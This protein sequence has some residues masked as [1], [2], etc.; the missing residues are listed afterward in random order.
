M[1]YLKAPLIIILR[2]ETLLVLPV[3]VAFLLVEAETLLAF[4]V[5]GV[6]L[7]S[8]PRQLTVLTAACVMLELGFMN[9]E[10]ACIYDL[11]KHGKIS[12]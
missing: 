11:F 6:R 8:P 12:Q 3:K 9:F 4:T 5:G 1:A 10:V 2:T 7:L